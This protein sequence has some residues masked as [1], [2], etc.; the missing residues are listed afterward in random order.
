M[1][2]ERQRKFRENYKSKYQPALQRSAAY[3]RNVLRRHRRSLLLRDAPSER[4]VG[5]V[6]GDSGVLSRQHG[7]VGDAPLRVAPT[8]R[9]CLL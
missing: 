7:G 4:K 2:S 9:T 3:R 8:H 6:V 1:M 5:M